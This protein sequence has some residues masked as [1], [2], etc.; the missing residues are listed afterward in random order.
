MGSE[1]DAGMET[2]LR[3]A[4]QYADSERHKA[5]EYSALTKRLAE[6]PKLSWEALELELAK[7]QMTIR[8]LQ[9]ELSKAQARMNQLRGSSPSQHDSFILGGGCTQSHNSY[10]RPRVSHSW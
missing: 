1:T 9:D 8:T 2:Y 5:K 4:E 6:M 7:A 3:L 10:N